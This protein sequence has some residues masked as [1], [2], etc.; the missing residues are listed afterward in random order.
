MFRGRGAQGLGPLWPS[1]LAFFDTLA[2]GGNI[3]LGILYVGSSPS[4]LG[5]VP[6]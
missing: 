5:T 6:T 2:L 3:L 4:H 1:H